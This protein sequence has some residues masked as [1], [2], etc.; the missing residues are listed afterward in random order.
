VITLGNP[1]L[2][3]QTANVYNFGVTLLPAEH[4]SVSVDYWR[5]KYDNQIGTQSPQAVI[6]SDPNGPQVVRDQ[7][8][9]AQTIYI[10]TFNAPSGTQ[11]SGIDVDAS[12]GFDWLGSKFALRDTLSYLLKYDI[13]TGSLV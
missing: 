6:N 9:V 12:Y 11:T 4:A 1:A 3:P 7:N 10:L 13:D 2:K 5:F 8:G